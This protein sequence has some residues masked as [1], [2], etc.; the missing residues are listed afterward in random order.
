IGVLSINSSEDPGAYNNQDLDLMDFISSQVS[1]AMERKVQEE[2]IQ[3]QGAR[4]AAIFESS[5]H[6]IWS[7]DR[8]YRFTS[9]NQNYSEALKDY[10]HIEPK[11][12]A[13]FL[14]EY[15]SSYPDK[16]KDFWS[17][18]YDQAF[19]GKIVNFQ[20]ALITRE[21]SKIWRD[22]FLN[23]IY[24]Q[25]GRIE[26]ISV[27]AND[28][29][30]KKL[31][32]IALGESEEKFRTIFESFQD[33]YFRCHLN[34][35][36]SMISPSIYE[37]LGY[38]SNEIIGQKIQR[39]FKSISDT[40]ILLEELFDQKSVRNFEGTVVTKENNTLQF[41]INIRLIHRRG[42]MFEIEGVA[43]DITQL[44]NASLELQQAKEVA[45]RSLK[46]KERFLANMSHE[47]RTPMN[48]IIGMIDLIGST[49]MNEEQ[50]EYVKTIQK[51]SETLLNILNDILDLSKIE[52]GKMELRRQPVRLIET[53][54]KLYDL[55]SQQ[56][57]LNNT[58]LYYHVNE[59]VPAVAM[60][61]ETR[62]M[63]VLSN[64]T[65]NAI[66]FSKKTGNI[67]LNIKMI[68][69]DEK[70][71]LFKVQIKDSGIGIS[72]IDQEKL[73]QSFS[74]VDTSSTKNYSGTGLGLAIS[75]ELVTSMGGEIGV[76]STPGLGST[77]WFT[78]RAE[79]PN[80]EEKKSNRKRE[81]NRILK[82]FNKTKPTIL[83]VDDNSV[84]RRVAC[85]ILLKAGCNVDEAE[86]GFTAIELVKSNKYDLI[87]MDIQMPGMDGVEATR[88]IRL[89]KNQTIPP[90]VAMTAYSMEEDRERFLS[91]GLDDYM[92]KPI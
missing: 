91:Q 37:V 24:L 14:D 19:E 25:D 78:F 49:E 88:Q 58:N 35:K 84:N 30:E 48:G 92:S 66:K 10:Y 22:V 87:F 43:R 28:I 59:N 80:E 31:A 56:A 61:D 71:Y 45:E 64:L 83:I 1:L 86:N 44:K 26:E 15:S 67:N 4:L 27:I 20:T 41:I 54:E 74:Q 29:T 63:Q 12:G 21:G 3:N 53:L 18:W 33:I 81:D 2:K 65:S 9:Y 85:Q 55:Y 60:A 8:Q 75:K 82:Q 90:V 23:P 77:F 5:T 72:K 79:V 13:T 6:Q 38:D 70:G 76:V 68:E 50:R 32:E 52:A 51:S 73:F 69:E 40:D 42:N 57:N 7:I 89:L 46:V 39:Y 62:I 11:L 36:I 16:V 47:I 17:K 34:G